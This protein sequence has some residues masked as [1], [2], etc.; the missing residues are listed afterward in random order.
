MSILIENVLAAAS[1]LSE[2]E[3]LSPKDFLHLGSRMAIDQ[4]LS[5]LAK[6][7][8]LIRIGRGTYVAPITSRFG[9]RPP[10]VEKTMKSL[11]EKTGE[12]VAS[13]GAAAANALGLTTQVPI[14]EIFITSGPSRKLTFASRVIELKQ[15]PHWQLIMSDKAAGMAIRALAWLGQTHIEAS[16]KKIYAHFST[17]E[18]QNLVA[19]R[20]SLPS[21]MA[22][23][24][25]K[26]DFRIKKHGRAISHS[27][28]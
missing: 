5:R 16:L 3:V 7:G 1:K 20:S 26:V 19:V 24:I 18:W 2:G 13:H 11:A 4:T 15:V 6:Q 14:R 12:I 10:A 22:E 27:G 9:S 23:N 8:Q 25:G 21:W 17:E 28:T